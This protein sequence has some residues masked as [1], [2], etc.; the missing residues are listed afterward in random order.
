MN[1]NLEDTV[2]FTVHC[3]L[4]F[5]CKK[6]IE[7]KCE[8]NS[9]VVNFIEEPVNNLVYGN[10]ANNIWNFCEEEIN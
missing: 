6:K 5:N 8:Y 2:F 3:E 7:S 4:F 10:I 9:Y 1:G